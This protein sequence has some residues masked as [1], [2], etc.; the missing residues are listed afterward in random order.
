MYHTFMMEILP[1]LPNVST[2]AEAFK[3]NIEF[4]AKW[5][6][7]IGGLIA[8]IGAVKLAVSVKSDDAK[9]QFTAVMTMVSGFMI[10]IAVGQMDLFNIPKTYTDAAATKE[11]QSIMLFIG[12]WTGRA[13]GAVTFFGLVALMLSVKDKNAGG[14]ATATRTVTAGATIIAISASLHLFV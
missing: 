6:G 8:F 1:Q 12:K 10:A 9:E 2:P 13:G 11:F 7:K 14:K 4:F 3:D 5:I